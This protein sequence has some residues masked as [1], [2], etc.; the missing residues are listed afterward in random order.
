M[1][2]LSNAD[3]ERLEVLRHSYRSAFVAWIS[4]EKTLRTPVVPE[5][6]GETADRAAADAAAEAYTDARD[7]LSEEMLLNQ[8]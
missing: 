5:G 7:R 3:A 8:K 6:A 1:S 4:A 2:S